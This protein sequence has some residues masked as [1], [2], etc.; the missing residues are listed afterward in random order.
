MLELSIKNI[1]TPIFHFVEGKGC[2]GVGCDMIRDQNLMAKLG[3]IANFN[4]NILGQCGNTLSMKEPGL[5]Q[6]KYNL[7]KH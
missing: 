6:G 3:L 5:R 4:F 2:T 7:A 1:I